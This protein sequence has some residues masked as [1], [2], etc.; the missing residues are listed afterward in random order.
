MSEHGRGAPALDWGLERPDARLRDLLDTPTVVVD[1]RVLRR[2]VTSLVGKL[3]ARGVAVRPHAKT[4]KSVRVARLLADLGATG[5]TTATTSEAEVFAAA[6]ITDIFVAY[7]VWA[8]SPA[9]AARLRALAEAV[10]QLRVGVDSVAAATA[11]GAALGRTAD[12][13]ELLIEVDCGDR[14]S[15]AAPADVVAIADAARDE[16]LRVVG[17]FTHGGHSYAAPSAAVG[18]ADD[19]VDS[20]RSAAEL[21]DASGHDVRVVSAGSTPTAMAS[22]RGGVTE[23]RPGTF[24]YGDRQQVMLGAVA[25]PDV[26]LGVATTVVS[27]AVPGQFVLDAGA[28]TI[29]KDTH[30]MLAGYGYLPAYPDA[31]ISRI[32]DHHAVVEVEGARP[33]VGEML[34][35]I[36]NHVCPVVNLASSMVVVDGESIETWPIDAQSCNA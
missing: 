23:V 7:P 24:V 26:A 12:S 33:S 34:I 14:R 11:L 3:G 32:Y 17:V 13:I 15:G 5:I 22:A 29:A 28:K 30:P 10:P 31:V 35:L 4:H 25:A 8:G 20:L 9:K 16:H 1:L 27:T 2:N 6:G 19:E 36:P 18:A 21:L